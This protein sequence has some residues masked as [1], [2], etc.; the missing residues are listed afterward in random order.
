MSSEFTDDEVNRMKP[1]ARWELE[2]FRALAK[3]QVDYARQVQHDL[4]RSVLRAARRVRSAGP[5]HSAVL[6]VPRVPALALVRVPAFPWTP[7]TG[8]WR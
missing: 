4:R 3:R 1:E 5:A 8:G 2:G 6:A 7:T